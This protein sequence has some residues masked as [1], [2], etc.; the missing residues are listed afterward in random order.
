VPV[1][2][3]AAYAVY[4]DRQRRDI[5]AQRREEKRFIPETFV[6]ANLAGLSAE[7]QQKLEAARPRTLAH[8]AR[9]EGMTPAAITLILA[10]LRRM[11]ERGDLANVS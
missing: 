7:L 2:I 6:Y 1:A 9:I 8:A 5:D 3:E 4:L 10:Q 11:E